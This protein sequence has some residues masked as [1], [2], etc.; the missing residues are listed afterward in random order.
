MIIGLI[1]LELEL[2]NDS[3]SKT[4]WEFVALVHPYR[5]AGGVWFIST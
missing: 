3:G 4:T 2:E 5:P 1:A